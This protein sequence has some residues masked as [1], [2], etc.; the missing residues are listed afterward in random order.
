MPLRFLQSD[1]VRRTP[2]SAAASPTGLFCKAGTFGPSG[3]GRRGRRPQVR[4]PAPQNF[5][6]RRRKRLLYN[7]ESSRQL[8]IL[9]V[10]QKMIT[11]PNLEELDW[12]VHG[13]GL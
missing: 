8:L 12:L 9:G 7:E 10:R 2:P 4:G 5:Q 3:T 13:F 1:Q 6:R 11:A